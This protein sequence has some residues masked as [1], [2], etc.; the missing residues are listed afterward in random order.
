MFIVD[1][2]LDLAYSALRYGRDLTQDVE[3]VRQSESRQRRHPNGVIT[4][5]IPDLLEGKI[6]LVFG[7]LFVMPESGNRSEPDNLRLVY[8]DRDGAYRAAGKELDYYHR[9][10]DEVERVRIVDD[11]DGLEEVVASHKDGE[12]P[13]LG[14]V[15]LMEGADPIRAPEEVEEWYERGVRIV[16]PAWDDTQYAAGA[17]RGR[18]GFTHEGRE[19]MEI[20]ADL[21]MILDITHL[22]EEASLEALERYEGAIVATH[23]NARALVPGARQLDDNQLRRLAERDGVV[24]IVL[25]NRFLKKGYTPSD[26]KES[27]TVDDVVAHIDHVCQLLGDANHVGIGSDLDGGFGYEDIPAEIDT[28][29]DL[30]KIAPAL[31]ERGYDEE[32]VAN[33]MGENWLR[34]LRTA[35]SED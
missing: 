2:H 1:A 3:T 6:G 14:I 29:A 16:G 12:T 23:A 8:S 18:G 26:P 10:A 22:S 34:R 4:T 17:W 11:L 21:G 13:L 31:R 30:A 5:T 9:L 35:F 19:L 27:V 25:Y 15:P 7:T 24:G 32:A 33:V 28:A 20:M